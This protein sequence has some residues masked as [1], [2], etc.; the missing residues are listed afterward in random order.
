[1]S[2]RIGFFADGLPFNGNTIRERSLG[3]SE[4]A[5]YYMARE[6]GSLAHKV[7]VICNCDHPGKYEGVEYVHKADFK[8][9]ALSVEFD[10]FI[11]SRFYNFFQVL[12]R[13]RLNI[14]WNHDI[15]DNKFALMRY[16]HRIHILFNLSRFHV[17]DYLG[18]IPQL[19]SKIF[20]TRN[21]IDMEMIQ[22]AV[23]G[24][25]KIAGKMIYASR[26][27]RGLPFLLQFIWPKVR[28][29]CPEATLHICT[30]DVDRQSLPPKILTLYQEIDQRVKD[31]PGVISLGTLPKDEYYGHLAEAQLV[32]YPCDF[33]EI[34][35]IVALEAQACKT[36]IVTTDDFALRET[37]GVKDWLVPGH[38][39]DREYQD[40]FVRTVQRLLQNS[41]YY[42]ETAQRGYD[43]VLP[44]FTW[45]VIAREWSSLFEFVH[46]QRMEEMGK[47]QT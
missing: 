33:P 24:R 26:P 7:W 23:K 20:Q 31:T 29:L 16:L 27:E 37:V 43:W 2:R 36:P 15:L 6:L 45:P 28:A 32:L 44:Q 13:S 39:Q 12:F 19:K 18:K 34:S 22:Q 1:M 5:V 10:V 41:E 17:E 8:N 47:S 42:L 30:Y 14:L 46:L 35:C 9:L 3:G 38:P 21:G 25:E 4:T 40:I 11:V